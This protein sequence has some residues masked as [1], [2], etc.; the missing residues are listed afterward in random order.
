MPHVIEPASTARSKCR[1]CGEKIAASVLRF[2]ESVPNPFGEGETTHWFHLECAAF[3]RPEPF[4]ETLPAAAEPVE[5]KERLEA[6][7]RQGL[8][9]PRLQRL[10]G[11]ERDPSGR[12]QCRQCKTVIAKGAWRIPVVVYEE[13]RFSP[14]GFIHAG[15]ARAYF[16]TAEGLLPRVRRFAP[17]LSE[18]DLAE[19][20]AEVGRP[21]PA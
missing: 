16:E 13:D 2:G 14:A 9:H 12:A 6:E 18:A 20:A 21:A 5:D 8:E 1:G 10:S 11:A 19:V 15:C 17:G 7:A 4:L 3:K